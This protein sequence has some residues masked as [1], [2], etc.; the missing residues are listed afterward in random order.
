MTDTVVDPQFA[1]LNNL[2]LMYAKGQ[3]VTQNFAEA[4]K[5]YQ[6]AAEQGLAAAQ[7]NLAVMYASGQGVAQ[8]Y[9]QAHL[10]YQA[11]ALQGMRI[12]V[13]RDDFPA[14][15]SGE[16]YWSDLVGL[17]VVN[18]EG[19]EF[20][21]VEL[22]PK[23]SLPTGTARPNERAS[24]LRAPSVTSDLRPLCE[25]IHECRCPRQTS[26]LHLTCSSWRRSPGRAR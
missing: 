7:S 23:L 25:L 10:L 4:A 8:N 5:C 2:G 3:G 12:A 22:P 1:A 13:S 14:P 18:R 15:A 11:A 16:F 19:I 6:Q 20:G 21:Q 26:R 17:Q 24:G 9:H